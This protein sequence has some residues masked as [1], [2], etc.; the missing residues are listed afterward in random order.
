[1]KPTLKALICLICATF[2]GTGGAQAARAG[3][4]FLVIAAAENASVVAGDVLSPGQ[5]VP[6]AKG[7]TALVLTR[8]GGVFRLTGPCLCRL[9][10]KPREVGVTALAKPQTRGFKENPDLWTAALSKLQ[11]LN[12]D[13]SR[14][15]GMTKDKPARQPDLWA[16]TV[17]GSGNRCVRRGDTYL[18]RG[19]SAAAARVELR[20]ATSRETGLTWPAGQPLMRLP[21]QFLEDGTSLVLSIDNQ[22]RELTVHVLPATIKE[23][24][25]GEI[26]IWMAARD[27]RH[28]AQFLVDGLNDG[29]LFPEQDRRPGLSEL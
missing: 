26:L 27:C 24:D 2:F 6:M 8:S 11:S 17:D 20:S 15:R 23:T 5:E 13:S 16:V 14:S 9:P 7:A 1:M 28:Q 18:W 22:P 12:E 29:S 4:E 19:R 25:W 3:S 10:G 21:T